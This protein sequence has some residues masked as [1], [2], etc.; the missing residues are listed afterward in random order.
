[1]DEMDPRRGYAD[2]GSR[3]RND[4]DRELGERNTSASFGKVEWPEK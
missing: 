1:M 2:G 3:K 4:A